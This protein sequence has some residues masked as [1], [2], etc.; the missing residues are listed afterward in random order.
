M[1]EHLWKCVL[2]KLV[3]SLS[4][5]WKEL[6]RELDN[7]DMLEQEQMI[8]TIQ[9]IHRYNLQDQVR[10]SL[11]YLKFNNSKHAILDII[12]GL[13]SCKQMYLAEKIEDI[14]CKDI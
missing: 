9:Y 11:V 3:K 4:T 6:F 1:D 2:E 10:C 8:R 14:V 5:N 12:Q 13:K 7:S